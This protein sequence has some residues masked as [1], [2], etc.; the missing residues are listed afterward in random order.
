VSVIVLFCLV[1]L[2][3]PVQLDCSLVALQAD[4]LFTPV[5]ACYVRLLLIVL[6]LCRP[7]LRIHSW[8]LQHTPARTY[9]SPSSCKRSKS[10]LRLPCQ[11]ISIILLTISSS[12]LIL[13]INGQLWLPCRLLVLLLKISSSCI[14]AA[15]HWAIATSM[16]NYS[17]ILLIDEQFS[18][19]TAH[20]WAVATSMLTYIVA[21]LPPPLYCGILLLISSY[22][23]GAWA[24][25][26]PQH[27]C[28]CWFCRRLDKNT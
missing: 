18:Y 3:T 6:Q 28:A 10:Q 20:H 8:S 27:A 11:L 24:L 13:L 15:H 22:Q 7:T 23:A 1:L 17:I 12:F 16:S 26:S 5:D 14:Y 4:L 2:C 25:I 19:H 21:S 9:C